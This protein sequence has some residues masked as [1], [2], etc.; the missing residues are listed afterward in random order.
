MEAEE[1]AYVEEQRLR[2]VERKEEARK[3]VIKQLKEEEE[4][5][6]RAKDDELPDDTDGINEEEERK[7]WALR[8]LRRLKRDQEKQQAE[9]DEKAEVEK[10]RTMTDDEIAA[11]NRR[12]PEKD[13]GKMKFL[14]KYFHK[15]A[16]YQDND[17]AIFKRDFNKATGVDAEVDKER[18]PKVLQV[19]NFGKMSRTKYTHLVDQDTTFVGKTKRELED[20]VEEKRKAGFG[21][22]RLTKR[23]LAGTGRVDEAFQRPKARKKNADSDSSSKK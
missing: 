21:S 14:Q 10:R 5:K 22:T 13:R 1:E 16:F 15:G 9:E 2:E 20:E 17:H 19:K 4:A 7:A 23:K 18:L 6:L 12:K 11:L 3:L 8:E